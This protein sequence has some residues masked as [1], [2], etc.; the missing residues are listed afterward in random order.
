MVFDVKKSVPKGQISVL[1][2][3][4]EQYI[5]VMGKLTK[6]V[7]SEYDSLCYISLNKMIGVL[8]RS[9]EA[10]EVD[11]KKFTFVDAVSKSAN[12]SIEED[13]KHYYVTSA[14]ALT[15][16]GIMITKAI[17][18]KKCKM[19]IFDNLSTLIIYNRAEVVSKF[20]HSIT[21]KL[22]SRGMDGVFTALEGDTEKSL[23]QEMGML[24]DNVVHVK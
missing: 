11:V 19:L 18:S 23:I 20:I 6:A 8:N 22:Q 13:E 10:N 15:E 21:N 3:P 17:D 12:P 24:V 1:V 7:A 2:V 16:L 14:S 4:N 5:S 9:L